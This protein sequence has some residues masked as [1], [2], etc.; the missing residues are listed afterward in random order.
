M[1]VSIPPMHV[2]SA[3]GFVNRMFEQSLQK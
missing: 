1:R 2:D 3:S